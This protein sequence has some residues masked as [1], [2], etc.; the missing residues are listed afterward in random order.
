MLRQAALAHKPAVINI[1]YGGYRG[2]HDG[3]SPLPLGLD[4]LLEGKSDVAIVV[5]AGN[6]YE[7]D[8]HA[9]YLAERRAK[10]ARVLT[11]V[12][13]P[14]DPTVNALEAWWD[15]NALVDLR[16]QSPSGQAFRAGHGKDYLLKRR[17]DGAIVGRI[18]NGTIEPN[19][20]HVELNA[21]FGEAPTPPLQLQALGGGA[22]GGPLT[23]PAPSG[24]WKLALE[25][26]AAT[27]CQLWI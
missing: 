16:L 8:C 24:A 15:G 6:G 22:A 20:L 27:A 5:S 12:L 17:P 3:T 4:Q 14:L 11:W 23:A 7:A 26:N 13:P 25:A 10:N 18:W 19:A 2:P 9:R 21:T 1:S